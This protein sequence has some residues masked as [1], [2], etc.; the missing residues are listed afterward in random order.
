MLSWAIKGIN[1]T[2]AFSSRLTLSLAIPAFFSPFRTNLKTRHGLLPVILFA[3]CH[4]SVE[5]QLPFMCRLLYRAYRCILC[6]SLLILHVK[7]VPTA[8]MCKR[9]ALRSFV[10][11]FQM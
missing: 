8:N 6:S 11:N 9:K 2:E 10:I 7:Q 5:P 1:G 4:P 3:L